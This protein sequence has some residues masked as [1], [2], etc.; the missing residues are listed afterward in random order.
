MKMGERKELRVKMVLP[1]R[2]SGTD[3]EGKPYS[4]LAHT[5]DFSRLGARLGGVRQPVRVGETLSLEYKLRRARF[6]IRWV[7]PPGTRSEHQVGIQSLE[8]ENF[9]WLDVPKQEYTD[10]ADVS[11]RRLDEI[12][13][14]KATPEPPR[15]NH[16]ADVAASKPASAPASEPAAKTVAGESIVAALEQR[17]TAEALSLDAALE[18]LA[19]NAQRLLNGTGAAIALPEKDEMVCRASAGRAPAIGVHFRVQTGLTAEAVRTGRIVTCHNTQ[20][21]PRVASEVCRKVGILSTISAPIALSDRRTAVLEVFAAESNAFTTAHIV[22]LEAL[23]AL[24]SRVAAG[25]V[26]S[27]SQAATQSSKEA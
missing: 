3:N 24:L 5:L 26:G 4:L 21:D 11:R 16:D 19:V 17:I 15:A 9:L 25:E 2:V 6:V 18:V 8:S 10:D 27:C 7:G 22:L 20:S 1:V 14:V 23:S 13:P 12:K